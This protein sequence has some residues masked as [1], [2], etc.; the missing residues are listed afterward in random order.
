MPSKGGFILA[1]NHLSFLDPPALGVACPRPLNYLAREDLF[2]IPILGRLLRRV[3]AIPLA[4]D[5]P[6]SPGTVKE[7]IRRLKKGEGLVI[8]PEGTRSRDGRLQQGWPGIGLIALKTGVPIVPVCL[9]GTEK[10]LPRDAKFIRC[11]KVSLCFGE[12]IEAGA[13]SS[14]ENRKDEYRKISQIVMREIARLQEREK[15]HTLQVTS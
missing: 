12:K 3:G 6:P 1:S 11:K 4:M 13:I 8:F 9:K 2:D 7:T 15:S 5:K 10:A 14:S